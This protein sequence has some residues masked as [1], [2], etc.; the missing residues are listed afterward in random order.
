MKRNFQVGK[1]VKDGGLEFNVFTETELHD[2][3]TA[4]LEVLSRTGLFVE[5]EEALDG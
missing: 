1:K 3:H 2:I 5:G 4:T